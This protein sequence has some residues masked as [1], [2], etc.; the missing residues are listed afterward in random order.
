MKVSPSPLARRFLGLVTLAV[1][2]CPLPA[3]NVR[4]VDFGADMCGY[5]SNFFRNQSPGAQG[6]RSHEPFLDVD[7]DGSLANNSVS[8]WDFSLSEPLTFPYAPHYDLAQKNALMYGGLLI[9]AVNN[10]NR[11]VSEGHMNANH[12]FRDDFNFMGLGRGQILDEES[13]EATAVFLWQKKDFLNDGEAHRVS[14]DNES[15]L[16]VHI[17]R[18]WG[19][20]HRGRWLVRDGEQFYLS[21]ATLGNVDQLIVAR[22][23][24]A[25]FG[26]KHPLLRKTLSIHPTQTRWAPYNPTGRQ[27][28]RHSLMRFDA[29]SATFAEHTFDDVTAVGFY[30]RRDLAKSY[31]SVGGGLT[32]RQPLALKWYA[33][34]CDARVERPDKPGHLV[35]LQPVPTGPGSSYFLGTSEV[36]FAQWEQVRR[37]A[38][39]NQYCRDL[40]DLG[41]A[42]IRDGSIGS[43]RVSDSPRVN[44]EPVTDITWLDAIAWCNALSEYEGL[45]PAYYT[46]ADY[47]QVLRRTFDRDHLETL[48]ERP[49]VY[50]KRDAA[51][52]RLPTASEWRFAALTGESFESGLRAPD[53]GTRPVRDGRADSLGLYDL[54]G[55][56]WEWVWPDANTTS[57]D[58]RT[59]EAFLALGGGFATNAEGRAQ[60]TFPFALQPSEGFPSIGLRIA[61]NG[62]GASVPATQLKVPQWRVQPG[63]VLEPTSPIN[64]VRLAAWFSEEHAFETVDNAG[65]AEPEDADPFSVFQKQR[66]VQQ[67]HTQKFLRKIDDAQLQAII[68]ENVV[69]WD[70]P[71]YPLRLGQGEVTYRVWN[72]VRGWAE[73]RGYRFNYAGDMGSMRYGFQT[74]RTYSPQEPVTFVCWHDALVWANA[75]SELLELEPVYYTDAEMTQPYR[76][77]LLFRLDTFADPAYPNAPAHIYELS[78][79]RPRVPAHSGSATTIY[80]AGYRNGMRLPMTVEFERAAPITRDANKVAATE[81]VAENSNGQT[82]PVVGGNGLQQLHGNVMAWSWD[83]K[84][85][86]AAFMGKYLLNGAGTFTMPANEVARS[87]RAYPEF[88][89]NARPYFGFRLAQSAR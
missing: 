60:N 3:A 8:G 84:H 16:H 89:S 46:D 33:F 73:T 40:G 22:S 55:N 49:T 81:A 32:N 15:Q 6:V 68:E 62:P 54:N 19:G 38:V 10:S 59:A 79:Q 27:G 39:T 88:P 44:T 13:F 14:F 41:Y 43:M 77:A 72:R 35:E 51:G 85:S 64:A 26:G 50:W 25:E 48:D 37:I 31:S 58:P 82:R 53:A 21:E 28:E 24:F 45:E 7:G 30:A 86:Y 47:T 65:L 74:E 18:Y 36:S 2:A 17:S 83:P 61:R 66:I 87:R 52:F 78:G 63:A 9:H 69:S 12:E 42:F 34:R 57:I 56:V 4:V 20:L 76:E 5:V 75:L 23:D 67:A 71:G 80:F 70:R 11:T 1:A 29:S